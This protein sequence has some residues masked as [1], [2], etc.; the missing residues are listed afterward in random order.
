MKEIDISDRL[1]LVEEMFRLMGSRGL[2]H[3]TAEDERADGRTVT[4]D[5]HRLIHF[6]SCSYLGLE[7]DRRLK[8]AACQAIERYGTQ[9]ASS[10]A[11]LSAPLYAELESHLAQMTG[12]LPVVVT[13]TTSLGHLAALPVLVGERDAVLCDIKVHAS[14]QAVLPTLRQTGVKCE[15]VQHNRIDR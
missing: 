15:F 11:Y 3:R 4:L 6:A 12:G 13:Q 2:V 9:F 8:D 1:R 14:V 7:T 5:G 10:R